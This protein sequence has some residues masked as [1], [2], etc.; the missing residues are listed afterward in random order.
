MK[1]L[2]LGG[3]G[4]L[5]HK[6][7]QVFDGL[8]ETWATVRFKKE[9]LKRFSFFDL[10]RVLDGVEAENFESVRRAVGEVAPDVAVN[11]MGVVKHLKEAE[12]PSAAIMTN[13][14]FPHLL[15][16][17]CSSSGIKLIQISTD[18]VFSGK[19]GNYSED[20]QPDPEDLYGRTKL[21]GEVTGKNS[22]T[23]RTSMIGREL[24][25]AVGLVEWFLSQKGG[26]VEGYRKA[27]F[28]GFTTKVLATILADIVAHHPRLTGLY[29]L[30]SYP[31]SKFELLWLIREIAGVEVEI[32]PSDHLFCDRSLD[33]SKFRRLTA[34]EPPS[35]RA[36]IE[37]LAVEMTD[38][39]VWRRKVLK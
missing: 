17:L 9:S 6:V 20:S 25:R 5:G 13:A 18:C 8:F 7:Y 38:Y 2:V 35:W 1:V 27:I 36:M 14:L 34:L 10:S 15:H 4:M 23:L 33:S 3:N 29:H 26:K 24:D 39:A 32:E 12:D 31:I 30:S 16:E 19:T 21:L 37:G 28:T 11:C 22:L